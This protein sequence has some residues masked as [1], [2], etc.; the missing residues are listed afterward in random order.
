MGKILKALI[1]TYQAGCLLMYHGGSSGL[2]EEQVAVVTKKY[3]DHLEMLLEKR[4][5]VF[6]DAAEKF[7]EL[8]T[9]YKKSLK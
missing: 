9:E 8:Y 1:K 5:Q 3:P 6:F 2:T 7:I 4:R